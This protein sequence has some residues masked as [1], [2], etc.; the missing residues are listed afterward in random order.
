[1][2]FPAIAAAVLPIVADYAPA[3][4]RFL[5]GERAEATATQVAKTVK[6]ITGEDVST[7]EGVQQAR[8]L[9]RQDPA[10]VVRMQTELANL[11]AELEKAY[12]EDVQDA[13]ERDIELKRMGYR[14]ARA[15]I[16][17]ISAYIAVLAI[18][19]FL[20]WGTLENEAVVTGAVG[21]FLI[22]IGGMFARN[23]GSAFDFEFGSSRGSKDKDTK[24]ENQLKVMRNAAR[25][26]LD[27]KQQF[28]ERA[29]EIAQRASMR[30]TVDALADARSTFRERINKN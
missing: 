12:L 6:Q 20:V 27:F 8:E 24:I 7:S 30:G 2:P 9:L 21:G 4:A 3:I 29:G 14:D 26:G 16:L 11:D 1:M 15:N 13:R 22:G 18:C 5:F 10:L 28:V 19:V 23:I 25:E 17:L